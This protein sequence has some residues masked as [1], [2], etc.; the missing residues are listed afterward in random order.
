MEAYC[1]TSSPPTTPRSDESRSTEALP[2]ARKITKQQKDRL[3]QGYYERESM[4]NLHESRIKV[5]RDRQERQYQ[6]ALQRMERELD[7]LVKSNEQ[8][9]QTLENQCESQHQ[10]AIRALEAKRRQLRWIWSIEEG[11]ERKK[12]ELKTGDEYGP[13]PE[14]SFPEFEE[15]RP[16]MN[17]FSEIALV[18]SPT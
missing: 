8:N 5:L 9:R 7:E 15:Y 16:G 13:L 17:D 6:N 2:P 10:E 18:Y 14:I 1:A 11:I 12:L 4:E 3:S